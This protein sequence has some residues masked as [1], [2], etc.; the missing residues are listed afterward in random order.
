[1]FGYSNDS[2]HAIVANVGPGN[3]F[4]PAPADRG[5]PTSFPADTTVANAFTVSWS[6]GGSV[7]WA[8]PGGSA[9]ASSS[10]PKC[11]SNPMPAIAEAGAILG[12]LVIA[13]FFSVAAFRERGAPRPARLLDR[14]LPR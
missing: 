2:S 4:T 10:S 11:S 8:L 14:M 6:G 1:V 12:L 13:V 5:Q 9:S 7:T 3:Q